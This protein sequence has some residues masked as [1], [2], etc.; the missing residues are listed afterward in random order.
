MEQNRFK[1]KVVWT[2]ILAIVALVMNNYGLWQFIGMNEE[3]FTSLVNMVL[4]VL[5]LVG[6]LNNPTDKENW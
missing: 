4:G 3:V 6:V 2:S 5:V 1:S